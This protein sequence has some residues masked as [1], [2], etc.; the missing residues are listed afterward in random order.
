MIPMTLYTPNV[1]QTASDLFIK[2]MEASIRERGRFM[3]VLSGGSTPLKMYD[4]L[5]HQALP[6]DKVHIFWGDER[7]TPHDHSDSNYGAAKKAFL[8]FIK[9]PE[10]NIHPMPYGEDIQQASK[11]YE[12]EIVNTLSENPIFD[13]TFLG[14]GEDAHIASLFPGTGAVFDQGL[15]TVCKPT[16][17]KHERLTLTS[18]ALSQSRVVAFLVSGEG[19]R[20]ALEETL[21]GSSDLDRYPARAI[22]AIDETLWITDIAGIIWS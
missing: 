8:D 12:Q 3:V 11:G 19:K 14:L 9:I 21:S 17:V 13:L 22:K 6:W 7:F 4:I 10:T 5:K 16:H 18:S 15:V 1:A 20:K 2:H